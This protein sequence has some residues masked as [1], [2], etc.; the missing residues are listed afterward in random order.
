MMNAILLN[1]GSG[2]TYEEAVAD[3][4]KRF[5]D[6]THTECVNGLDFLMRLTYVVNLWRNEECWA[7][8]DPPKHTV[9]GYLR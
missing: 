9:E 3:A 5:P 2:W 4:L 6:C 1:N 7:A 8:G